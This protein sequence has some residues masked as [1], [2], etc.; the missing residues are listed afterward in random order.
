MKNFRFLNNGKFR[1]FKQDTIQRT[2]MRDCKPP[3]NPIKIW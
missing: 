1:E 2:L 3:K